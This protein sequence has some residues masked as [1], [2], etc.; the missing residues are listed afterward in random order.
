MDNDKLYRYYW[1]SPYVSKLPG[2]VVSRTIQ[3]LKFTH[4]TFI[5]EKPTTDAYIVGQSEG[6]G[7]YPLP[8]RDIV[9][10]EYKLQYLLTQMTKD[11]GLV[12][13]SQIEFE[14]EIDGYY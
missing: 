12:L 11:I 6:I 7:H 8:E 10:N 14:F 1:Y 9:D 13:S 4:I 5:N 3:D 2:G